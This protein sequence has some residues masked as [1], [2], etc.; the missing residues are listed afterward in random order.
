MKHQGYLLDTN[1]C[2]S[3]LKNKYGVR[4]AILRIKPQNCFVSEI[5]LAEL[6]FGASNSNNRDARLKDVAFVINHFR[7]IEISE[8]LPLYGDL[9]A[10]L[11]KKGTPIDD[12]DLLIGSA[13]IANNLVMVTDNIKHLCKLPGIVVENWTER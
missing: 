1:I 2:I 12:F 11:R 5:T 6:Y 3:M 9:K 4:E 13:A 7:I 10:E 8:T